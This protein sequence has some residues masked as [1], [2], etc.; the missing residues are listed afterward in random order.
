MLQITSIKEE[1]FDI[2]A[3]IDDAFWCLRNGM[4]TPSYIAHLI[5]SARLRGDISDR[6]LDGYM[7]MLKG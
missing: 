2:H 1:T 4:V 7:E 6:E 5:A 3:H